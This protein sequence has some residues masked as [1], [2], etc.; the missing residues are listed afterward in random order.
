VTTS[1]KTRNIIIAVLVSTF[2]FI[3]ALGGFLWWY[4][5]NEKDAARNASDD[6]AGALVE[7]DAGAAPDGGSEYVTGTRKYFGPIREAETVDVRQVDNYGDTSNTADD[8]SWWTSTVFLRSERGAALLLVTFADSIDPRD[9]T[10]ESIR[11]LNPRRVAKGALTR[12]Q[13]QDARRGFK[14]R[15]GKTA[16]ALVLDGTFTEKQ[17]G[18]QPEPSAPAEQSP[19]E[20]A[21][22]VDRDAIERQQREGQRRLECVQNARGD[23]EKLKKC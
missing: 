2:L 5:G 17:A 4:E 11:E 13:S 20:P 22:P 6:L 10:V 18:S 16:N 21:P 14:S 19:P 8:R 1:N 3:G 9:A 7:N 15:G 23:I 12:E